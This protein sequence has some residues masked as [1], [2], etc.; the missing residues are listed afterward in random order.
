[1]QRTFSCSSLTL[2]ELGM[3]I[4]AWPQLVC[5]CRA[6]RS[7]PLPDVHLVLGARLMIFY[8]D[9]AK[10][11]HVWEP[12]SNQPGWLER[13]EGGLMQV[14]PRHALAD[15]IEHIRQ[16]VAD[17]EDVCNTR[18]SQRCPANTRIDRERYYT[19]P[20]LRLT[21]VL[22]GHPLADPKDETVSSIQRRTSL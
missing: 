18:T 10:N 8:D 5:T 13:R 6:V 1:M 16:K 12:P 14:L 21:Q 19:Y 15:P 11:G 2:L 4:L 9:F 17:I 7:P 3:C 22:P 20:A